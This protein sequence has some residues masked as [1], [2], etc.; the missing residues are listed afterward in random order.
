MSHTCTQ[1]HIIQINSSL[2]LLFMLNSDYMPK[3]T[4]KVFN[5][6]I[7]ASSLLTP[8]PEIPSASSLMS[9]LSPPSTFYIHALSQLFSGFFT[10]MCGGG[11]CTFSPF[12]AEG[13]YPEA[14]S[15]P[16]WT[17]WKKWCRPFSHSA[18]G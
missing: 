2:S 10:Q 4:F 3:M 17:D 15:L 11:A 9:V 13:K 18:R 14:S 8:C 7:P 12:C 6:I 16:H 1:K 5:C